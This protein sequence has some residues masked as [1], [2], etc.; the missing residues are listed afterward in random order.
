MA[1]G[2]RPDNARLSRKRLGLH[3]GG[4]RVEAFDRFAGGDA[5]VVGHEGQAT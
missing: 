1:E 3:H 2:H 4:I 5:V